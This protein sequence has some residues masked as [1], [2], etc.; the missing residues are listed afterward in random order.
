MSAPEERLRKRAEELLKHPP[1]MPAHHAARE[2]QEYR[3]KR[4]RLHCAGQAYLKRAETL[5]EATNARIY[6]LLRYAEP[7]ETLG[8]T[9]EAG[10]TLGVGRYPVMQAMMNGDGWDVTV[11]N[12]GTKPFTRAYASDDAF[13]SAMDDLLEPLVAS[14]LEAVVSGAEIPAV[15]WF[16]RSKGARV[17]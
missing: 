11:Y 5:I 17:A 3:Q 16:S 2:R 14:A 1:E 15:D 4:L 6:H 7:E 9:L 8:V 12:R 10:F 13:G